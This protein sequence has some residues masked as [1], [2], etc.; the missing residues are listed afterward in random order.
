MWWLVFFYHRGRI[1]SFTVHVFLRV[2]KLRFGELNLQGEVPNF[3]YF[4]GVGNGRGLWN[5]KNIDK[6]VLSTTILLLP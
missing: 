2:T 6:F 4:G 3:I 5:K 1:L